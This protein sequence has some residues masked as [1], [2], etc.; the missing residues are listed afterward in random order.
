MDS[1]LILVKLGLG[2]RLYCERRGGGRLVDRRL[3]V[4]LLF[5]MADNPTGTRSQ[6]NLR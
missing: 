4:L 1:L 2:M 6:A 5:V 3:L